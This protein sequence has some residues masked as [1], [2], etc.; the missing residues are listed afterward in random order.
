MVVSLNKDKSLKAVFLQVHSLRDSIPSPCVS[1][2]QYKLTFFFYISWFCYH[3]ISLVALALSP[4]LSA[5]Q[6]WQRNE[7]MLALRG[8]WRVPD[9]QL[10]FHE[11]CFHMNTLCGERRHAEGWSFYL[12][13]SFKWE[14]NIERV[15]LNLPGGG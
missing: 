15:V 5:L 13:Q 6:G 12:L 14:Q 2:Y 3:G 10:L 1:W 11:N 4:Q 7:L 9:V 8:Y